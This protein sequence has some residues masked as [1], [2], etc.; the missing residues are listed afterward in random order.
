MWIEVAVENVDGE[1]AEAVAEVMTPIAES[2][3]V[4][5][6][7]R[8]HSSLGEI[9]RDDPRSGIPSFTVRLYLEDREDRPVGETGSGAEASLLRLQ[10]ALHHLR[11]IRPFPEATVRTLTG[12]DWSEAWKKPHGRIRPGKRIVVLPPWDRHP[13]EAGELPVWIEP[14][15]AFG[16]GS[17][18]STQNC[19]ELLESWTREGDRVLDVGCGSG[20]LSLC[21]LRLG[22][23]Q[24]FACDLEEESVVATRENASR[25]ELTSIQVVRGSIPCF[26]GRFDLIAI[27]ILASVIVSL[28]PEAKG[29]LASGGRFVLGGILESAEDRV[30]AS[31]KEIDARVLDRSLRGE[32]VGLL[33]E[34]QGE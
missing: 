28:L 13:L 9:D 20:V 5:E 12:E 6:E 7:S 14:G 19:V 29:L 31:L 4:V 17:H 2:G 18:P 32:W 11:A 26:A 27:N 1:I 24:V 3:V 22:A 21:A 8:L 15:M 25:N 10:T 23:A 34:L 30:L 16:V 33:A